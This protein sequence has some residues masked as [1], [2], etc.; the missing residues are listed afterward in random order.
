[1]TTRTP[2][3]TQRWLRRAARTMVNRPKMDPRGEDEKDEID[4]QGPIPA[5]DGKLPRA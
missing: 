4:G 2:R 1:M 3:W 5:E